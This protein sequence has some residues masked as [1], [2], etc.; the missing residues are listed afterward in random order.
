LLSVYKSISY[1]IT[2]TTMSNSFGFCNFQD[3][4]S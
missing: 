1:S 4:Y 2:V 3:S